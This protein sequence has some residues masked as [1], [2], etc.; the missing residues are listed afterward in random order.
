MTSDCKSSGD[1]GDG[2]SCDDEFGVE[3]ITIHTVET[4]TAISN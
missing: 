2:E 1:G 3:H 4:K